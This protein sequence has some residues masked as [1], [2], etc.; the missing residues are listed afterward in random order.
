LEGVEIPALY[1]IIVTMTK[2]TELDGNP[3]EQVIEAEEVATEGP[4]EEPTDEQ[5][6]ERITQLKALA[7]DN[8]S[9]IEKLQGELKQINDAIGTLSEKL[10]PVGND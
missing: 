4:V 6:Q 9:V 8:I 1:A 10:N 3:E 2:N 7:Y 5:I